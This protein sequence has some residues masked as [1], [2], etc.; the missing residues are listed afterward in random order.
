M[1]L[2]FSFKVKYR[3]VLVIVSLIF[4]YVCGF[5]KCVFYFLLL[6]KW[7]YEKEFCDIVIILFNLF[8]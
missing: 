6:V 7:E 2:G 3:V 5:F 4:S 1:L 8:F